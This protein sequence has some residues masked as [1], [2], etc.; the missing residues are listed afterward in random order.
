MTT[1]PSGG[2]GVREANVVSDDGCRVANGVSVWGIGSWG[3]LASGNLVCVTGGYCMCLYLQ[4][5]RYLNPIIK[6]LII[7]KTK[8]KMNEDNFKILVMHSSWSC[9][10]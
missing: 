6:M 4:K 8:N 2:N 7:S 3:L 1:G 5:T 9:S 10:S